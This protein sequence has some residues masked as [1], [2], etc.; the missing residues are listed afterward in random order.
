VAADKESQRSAER[1]EREL[2]YAEYVREAVD[3]YIDESLGEAER[4]RLY[5]AKR[6]EL[7]KQHS[8]I[9]QWPEEQVRDVVRSAMQAEIMSRVDLLSFEEFCEGNL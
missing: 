8:Y 1:A 3:R 7:A 5:D 9:S 6:G 4:R 2:A